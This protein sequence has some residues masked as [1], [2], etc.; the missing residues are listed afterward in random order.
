MKNGPMQGV[1]VLDV[2]IALT[3]P[4]SAALLADQGADVIKVERPDIGDIA[5][6]IGVA[7]NGMS[8]LYLVCNR[9]KR[10]IAVDLK[11]PEGAAC[12]PGAGRPMPTWSSRTTVPG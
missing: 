2:S 7:V 3:G 8:S 6:W 11:S 1:R 9:G 5:R 4:Y 12:G 10:S